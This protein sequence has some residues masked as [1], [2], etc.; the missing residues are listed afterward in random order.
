MSSKAPPSPTRRHRQGS[1]LLI[2]VALL[3]FLT[4]FSTA[5]PGLTA[6]QSV[7]TRRFTARLQAHYLARA[8]IEMAIG[9]LTQA[10][11]AILETIGHVPI[12]SSHSFSPDEVVETIVLPAQ[13]L[14]ENGSLA[15]LDEPLQEWLR[16]FLAPIL[17]LDRPDKPA[18][19][20]PAKAPRIIIIAYGR[21]GGERRLKAAACIAVLA[22]MT[23]TGPSI[24]CRIE[25]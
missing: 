1:A 24:V 22:Q 15:P 18:L 16:S 2:V 11:G 8:G 12:H 10:P 13:L 9:D 5:F 21:A 23:A 20:Q 17:R 3:G 6:L 19:G 7:T 4:L 25:R 14:L